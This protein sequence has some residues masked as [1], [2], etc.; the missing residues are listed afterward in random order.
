MTTQVIERHVVR[1][2]ESIFSPMVVSAM[3]DEE[4]QELASEPT[5]VVR[6][7][8]FL[9]DRIKKLENGRKVLRKVMRRGA[10]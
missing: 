9:E 8:K 5:A 3:S 10:I 7:R 4:L 2:L 1:G 6:Q